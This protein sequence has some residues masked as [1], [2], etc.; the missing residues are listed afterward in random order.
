MT[1]GVCA[2]ARAPHGLFGCQAFDGSFRRYKPVRFVVR[3]PELF[4]QDAAKIGGRL[5]PRGNPLWGKAALSG[6]RLSVAVSSLRVGAEVFPVNLNRSKYAWEIFLFNGFD[7]PVKID[8]TNIR[9]EYEAA[10][11]EK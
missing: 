5:I 1:G 7:D 6:E 4:K 11:M 10:Q 8:I 2:F 3:G 9:E